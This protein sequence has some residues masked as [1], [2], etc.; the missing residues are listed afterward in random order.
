MASL[1]QG[2]GADMQAAAAWR[3]RVEGVKSEGERERMWG[4]GADARGR[5]T[6]GFF[7]NDSND[8]FG[9]VCG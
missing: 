7:L 5:R 8:L 3:A 4:A 6:R 2:K 9:S 1:P